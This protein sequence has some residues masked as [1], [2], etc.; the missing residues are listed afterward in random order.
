[1]KMLLHLGPARAITPHYLNSMIM[2][3]IYDFCASII[4]RYYSSNY[5]M[6][7]VNIIILFE[8]IKLPN[9]NEEY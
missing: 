9:Q 7:V 5:S 8:F 2:I 4:F 6:Q 1:M 3:M